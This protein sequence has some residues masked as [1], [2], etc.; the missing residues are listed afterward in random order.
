[1]LLWL[2]TGDNIAVSVPV[3][4]L[5]EAEMRSAEQLDS[6]QRRHKE[7]M[8]RIERE[9]VLEVENQQIRYV[10]KLNGVFRFVTVEK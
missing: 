2:V 7:L 4:Q 6:E 9:K 8:Q 5:R 10:A 1:M 3:L